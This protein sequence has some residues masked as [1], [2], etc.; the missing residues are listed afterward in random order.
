MNNP[1]LAWLQG[2]CE[3]CEERSGGA[4]GHPSHQPAAAPNAAARQAGHGPGEAVRPDLAQDLCQP[5]VQ[6]RPGAG[7]S[8]TQV[9]PCFHEL[10]LTLRVSGCYLFRAAVRIHVR[11]S[12]PVH[13]CP[14]MSHRTW[15]TLCLGLCVRQERL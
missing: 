1:V 13:A 14:H 7:S 2:A 4:R 3:P 11:T 6:R 5:D 10:G 12:V 8:R 15:V 9:H